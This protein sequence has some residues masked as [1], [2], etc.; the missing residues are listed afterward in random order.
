MKAKYAQPE[1]DQR[2][3]APAP[4]GDAEGGWSRRAEPVR[5]DSARGG[6]DWN[7]PRGG[8]DRSARGGA[9]GDFN[10]G[11]ARTEERP[12]GG[13]D[14]SWGRSAEQQRPRPMADRRDERPRDG[15]PGDRYGI[16]YMPG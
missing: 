3:R 13:N 11:P 2:D 8:D 4:R 12:R 15:P 9:G 6:G 14:E 5:D 16:E 1:R 10:R 7:R